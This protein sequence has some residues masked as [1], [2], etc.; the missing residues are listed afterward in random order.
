[1]DGL[2]TQGCALGYHI[3]ATLWLKITRHPRAFSSFPRG[4]CPHEGG[5]GDPCFVPSPCTQGEGWGEGLNEA[6]AGTVRSMV[7]E[8]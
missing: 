4:A 3:A 5:G 1:M 8:E 2:V 7:G 6:A